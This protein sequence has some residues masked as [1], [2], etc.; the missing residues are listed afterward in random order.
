[1]R[2]CVGAALVATVLAIPCAAEAAACR[3]YP[4]SVR[5]LI[6]GRVEAIRLLER[7]A[8]DRLVGLDTRT[9][10]FLAGE[11]RKAAELIASP[12]DL[13][14]EDELQRCRN[15]VQPV[16]GICRGAA[17]ALA[18]VFDEHEV[19]TAGTDTR[20]TYA[21]AM[22]RCELLMKLPPLSTAIRITN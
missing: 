5:L 16:R 21:E 18:A 17:L 19:G 10:P 7:E 11:A 13:A 9:F 15:H 20:R 4:E 14:E 6:K 3:G 8:A 1:M 2:L 22:P 12:A